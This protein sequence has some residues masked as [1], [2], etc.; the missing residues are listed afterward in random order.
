M[1]SDILLIT[2]ANVLVS[3]VGLFREVVIS[4]I[5]GT[6]ITAD[7]FLT[8]YLLIE[9]FNSILFIGLI[10]GLSA[11][12]KRIKN[13]DDVLKFLMK[14]LICVLPIIFFIFT[15]SFFFFD[16][17]QF[18]ISD[19]IYDENFNSIMKYSSF[20]LPVSLI[21]SILA[22]FLI[23]K[24][25]YFLALFSK[26]INYAFLIIFLLLNPNP[27]DGVYIGS[28]VSV[29]Y[30]MQLGFLSLFM[31]NEKLSLKEVLHFKINIYEILKFSLPWMLQPML[32]PFAGN[33]IGRYL[34]SGF[35]LGYVSSINYA[36]KILNAMNIFTFSVIL[37]GFMDS[38]NVSKNITEIKNKINVSLIRIIFS[39]IPITIFCCLY[40]NQIISIIFERGAFDSVSTQ[41]TASA[42]YIFTLTLY[43]IYS[44]HYST[45]K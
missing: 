19:K 39:T 41:L 7:H 40:S 16:L 20:S 37:V 6:S 30:L 29:A 25:K 27:Y 2:F 45:K 17:S 31:L 44:L 23:F 24:S 10:F 32:M 34:V 21:N 4:S 38:L 15:L 8:S 36:S 33:I 43:T 28:L 13:S 3:I 5:Y 1:F 12:L 22:T 35:D 14:L 42:F 18:F 11:Y 9:E 26:F